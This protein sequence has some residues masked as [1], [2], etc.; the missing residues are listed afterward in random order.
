MFWVFFVFVFFPHVSVLSG[1]REVP[2]EQG[3]FGAGVEA[4]KV[5]MC[6]GAAASEIQFCLLVK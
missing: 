1:W 5:S 4:V 2:S 6:T 3:E